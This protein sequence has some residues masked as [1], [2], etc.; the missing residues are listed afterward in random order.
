[1]KTFT[2][3]SLYLMYCCDKVKSQLQASMYYKYYAQRME[4][5]VEKEQS[6]D[7]GCKYRFDSNTGSK[8]VDLEGKNVP[9]CV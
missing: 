5:P 1:M 7:P 8:T 2:L 9:G 6:E 4:F 3:V